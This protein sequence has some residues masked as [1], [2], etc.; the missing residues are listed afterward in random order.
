M[1]NYSTSEEA[2]LN[3]NW[4]IKL[5]L[6]WEKNVLLETCPF[7]VIASEWGSFLLTKSNQLFVLKRMILNR[8]T[9]DHGRT[10]KDILRNR[11]SLV[12]DWTCRSVYGSYSN[13]EQVGLKLNWALL[14][15]PSTYVDL[16]TVKKT[17]RKFNR[18]LEFLSYRQFFPSVVYNFFA[19]HHCLF[20]NHTGRNK[21]FDATDGNKSDPS[22][23]KIV[24]MYLFK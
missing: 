15:V 19:R 21:N 18:C 6:N 9:K 11:L 24:P 16:Y 12:W 14:S 5:D 8:R 10:F 17:G 23:K 3:I 1:S 4:Y 22:V 20:F 2:V 13:I 7:Y